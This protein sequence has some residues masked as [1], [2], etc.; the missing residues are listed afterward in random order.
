VHPI[1]NRTLF[2]VLD[3]ID[4]LE[5]TAK[6]AVICLTETPTGPDYSRYQALQNKHG[7]MSSNC[8]ENESPLSPLKSESARQRWDLFHRAIAHAKQSNSAALQDGDSMS[9]DPKHS[10]PAL[11]IVK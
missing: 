1:Q 8:S 10:S 6:Q 2:S 7:S 4:R 3:I 5:S 9:P 11:T